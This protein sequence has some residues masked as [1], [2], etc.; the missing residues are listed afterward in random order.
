MIR[1]LSRI[2]VSSEFA[3]AYRKLPRNLKELAVKK[4][5][6][7]RQNAFDHRLH[8]HKLK[9]ALKDYWAYSITDSHRVLFRFIGS[10]EVIYFDIG[11]HDIYR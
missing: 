6:M 9:G 10:D 2:H 3:R 11:T 8:T 1:P 4:E 7:F 5:K